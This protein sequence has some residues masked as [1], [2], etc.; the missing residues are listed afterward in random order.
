MTGEWQA[1][2]FD[3]QPAGYVKAQCWSG[4]WLLIFVYE[5]NAAHS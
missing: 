3:G 2:G 4:I 1:P 5:I